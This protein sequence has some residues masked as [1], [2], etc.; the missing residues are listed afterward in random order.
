MPTRPVRRLGL[1]VLAHTA[2]HQGNGTVAR[3]ALDRA[4]AADPAYFLAALLDRLVTEG[5]RPRAV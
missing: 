4:R 2:W 5:T 1:T 3:V